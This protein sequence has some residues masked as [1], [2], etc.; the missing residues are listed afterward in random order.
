MRAG[1]ARPH[2]LT[3]QILAIATAGGPVACLGAADGGALA[4][5]PGHAGGARAA[6][7]GAHG[8]LSTGADGMMRCWA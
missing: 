4:A 2:F 1:P 6:L 3:L 5:L 7:F 8:L